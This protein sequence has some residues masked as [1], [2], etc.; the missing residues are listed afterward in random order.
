MITEEDLF[1]WFS[2]HPPIE[3]QQNKYLRIREA[4]LMFA[5]AIIFDT[6]ASPDQTTAI[7]KIREAVMTANA[8]IA[9]R[10]R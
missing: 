4:A 8:S 10:G 3:D 1:N 9:C 2:Y 6:P 5:R 7:R